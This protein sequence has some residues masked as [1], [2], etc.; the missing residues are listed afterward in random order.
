MAV[1]TVFSGLSAVL[2]LIISGFLLKSYLKS[3][4]ASLLAWAAGLASY[5]VSHLLDAAFDLSIKGLELSPLLANYLRGATVMLFLAAV[6][7]GIVILLTDKKLFTTYL[8]LS[9]LALHA[10]I[11]YYGATALDI[12]LARALVVSVITLPMSL[13]IGLMFISLE[14]IKGLKG[15]FVVGATWLA[16]AALL[17]L[18]LLLL[19]KPEI[20]YFFAARSLV[21]VLLFIGF[22]MLLKND[23]WKLSRPKSAGTGSPVGKVTGKRRTK[24]ARKGKR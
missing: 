23:Y 19:G 7:Y 4:N 14:R 8:P 2:S 5:S 6:Y 12:A 9:L 15:G 22:I 21:S 18:Y 16:Y 20:I 1:T 17:P 24:S 11:F 13:A 10:L 3:R